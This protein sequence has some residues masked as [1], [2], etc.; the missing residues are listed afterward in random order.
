M[1]PGGRWSS[2]G[3]SGL[4]PRGRRPGSSAGGEGAPEEGALDRRAAENLAAYLAEQREHTGTLP[5]D[6]SITVERFRDE[7]G[8][9]RVCLL[10]PWVPAFTR[11]G[12][13][14]S[15]K[16]SPGERASR[17]RCCGPMT[18]SCCASPAPRSCLPGPTSFPTPTRWRTSSRRSSALGPL[19]RAFPGERSRALLLPRGRPE[20]RRPLW[21]QRLKA[22]GVLAAVRAYPDFPIVLETYRQALRDIFDLPSLVALLRRVRSR[23]IEVV[24]VETPSA[25]PFARSLVF[26]HVAAVLYDQDTPLASARPRP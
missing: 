20:G 1:G 10:S 14:R 4:R 16:Y 7:L 8:D 17:C 9:W 13:W 22:Q 15:S 12:P 23:E 3:R 25:S 26:A 11:L 18:A 2:A 19:R 21:A 5:T 6:R 24:E